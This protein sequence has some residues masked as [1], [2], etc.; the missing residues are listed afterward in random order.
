MDWELIVVFFNLAFSFLFSAS[1]TALTALGRLEVEK[2]RAHGGAH[3]RLIRKWIKNPNRIL[4]EIL[5]GNNITNVVASAVF[6]LWVSKYHPNNIVLFLLVFTTLLI[7][8]AEIV[9]KL[10]ARQWA[11]K[12]APWS[13]RFLE[14]TGFL[15]WPIVVVVH[16]LTS[17]IARVGMTGRGPSALSEEEL[18]HTIKI[19]T[20]EGGI[21]EET[22]E[23][24]ENLMDFPD[25]KARDIMQPRSHI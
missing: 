3:E 13:M 2:I 8:F 5:V 15:L 16:R 12:V 24:L 11:H 25:T 6:T 23:V 21:D 7:I 14:S 19:A 18:T 1:E 4:T 20:K 9:P 22:G 17:Q 10:A